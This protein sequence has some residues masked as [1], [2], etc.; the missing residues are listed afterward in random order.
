MKI[1]SIWQ[2]WRS[3]R[4]T[5]RS[6]PLIAFVIPCL[7]ACVG[8]PPAAPPPPLKV[9][10][11]AAADIN[12]DARQRPSPV[13]VRVY[14]LKS[15]AAFSS[16]DFLSLFSKEQATLGADLLQKEEFQIRPGEKMQLSLTVP[17]EAKHIAVMSAFRDVARAQWRDTQL[18]S[19]TDPGWSV[20]LS[21]RNVQLIQSP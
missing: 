21:G 15:V 7:I 5:W 1:C 14:L 17:N 12:P 4:S 19:A 20:H 8:A 11:S 2:D 18:V 10:I 9:A 16:A 13:T 3:R 6:W